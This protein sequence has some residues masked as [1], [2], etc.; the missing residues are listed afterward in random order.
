MRRFVTN[1]GLAGIERGTRAY[2][3]RGVP[4]AKNPL[5]LAIY[6]RLLWDLQPGT[7]IEVGTQWGGSALWLADVLRSYRLSAEVISIDFLPRAT[8]SVPGVRFLAGDVLQLAAVL[9]P[10]ETARLPH[11][12]LVLEDSAH[13]CTGCTAAL[14][15]FAGQMR[16][17]DMLVVEDG[18]I[19]DLGRSDEYGGGPN[20]AVRD[21]LSR[22]PAVF[23]VAEEY[24]D[25]FGPN[26]TF[27]PNGYLRH[28]GTT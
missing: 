9:P 13:T 12:W 3:Y 27:N 26:A 2:T 10:E 16:A 28:L 17:G 24:C 18:V 1:I 6:L 8:V 20:R 25:M 11:P 15:F 7:V 14:E 4:C 5:D 23:A 22:H 21:F 19:D